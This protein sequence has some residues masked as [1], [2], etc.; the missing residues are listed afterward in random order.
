[1]LPAISVCVH[2]H[3][4]TD[5]H[6]KRTGRNEEEIFKH[7]VLKE[8]K[9]QNKFHIIPRENIHPRDSWAP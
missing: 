4:N 8:R 7:P 5:E 2:A 6:M 3:T 1:M 9:E